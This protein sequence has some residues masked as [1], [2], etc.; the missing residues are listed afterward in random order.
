MKKRDDKAVN[1]WPLYICPSPLLTNDDLWRTTA[2]TS[3][4]PLKS[5]AGG[6]TANQMQP[7][8]TPSLAKLTKH[9]T[10]VAEWEELGGG[11]LRETDNEQTIK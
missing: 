8:L 1:Y 4:S 10:A 6:S 9:R 3:L 2:A 5:H 7:Q 11:K